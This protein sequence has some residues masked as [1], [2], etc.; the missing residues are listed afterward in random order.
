VRD[1]IKDLKREQGWS[2]DLSIKIVLHL[3]HLH[4]HSINLSLF[5]SLLPLLLPISRVPLVLVSLPFPVLPVG[6]STVESPDISS[7][8][9]HIRSKIN[10]TFSSPLGTQIKERGTRPTLQRARISRKLDVSI[11]PK[12]LLHRS[13]NR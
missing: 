12:W 1:K 3:S 7:R 9:A 11:I 4:I 13:A 5:I 2:S 6:A 10:P 8:T